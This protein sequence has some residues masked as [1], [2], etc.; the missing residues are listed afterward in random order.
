M[1]FTEYDDVLKTADAINILSLEEVKMPNS[2]TSS[3]KKGIRKTTSGGGPDPGPK[4]GSR[5]RYYTS[6]GQH[7]GQQQNKYYTS[8]DMKKARDISRGTSQVNMQ[9]AGASSDIVRSGH[10]GKTIF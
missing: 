1:F 4:A 8:H 2:E 5:D 3:S 7:V 10:I 6:G 9:P